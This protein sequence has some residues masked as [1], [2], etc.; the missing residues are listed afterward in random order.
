MSPSILAKRENKVGSIFSTVTH[1]IRNEGVIGLYRGT[2]VSVLGSLAG[3]CMYFTCYDMARNHL[4][5][6]GSKRSSVGGGQLLMDFVAGFIAETVSCLVW[7]PVDVCKERLQTQAQLKV[8]N[9]KGSWDAMRSIVINDG[10]SQLYR[11]YFATLASFGPMS[12]LYFTFYEELKRR[13]IDP[14]RNEYTFRRLLICAGGAGLIS[15]WLTTPLDLVKLRLQVQRR[16]QSLGKSSH[17]GFYY[18]HFL[19]GLHEVFRRE[20][21]S[22][23]FRGSIA[24]A[25]FHTPATA[26]TVACVETVRDR[27]LR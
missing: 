20:G 14:Q 15:S 8:S 21:L 12:A 23:A 2:G 16:T 11:G 1:T 4:Q 9:Y 25:T 6:P 10:V 19:H 7:V 27:Y 26:I 18:R 13:L 3:T 24:R 17:T 22:G 5:R